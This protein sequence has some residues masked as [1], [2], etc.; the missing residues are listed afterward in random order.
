MADR[1][2][3]IRQSAKRKLSTNWTLSGNTIEGGIHISG[4]PSLCGNCGSEV[5]PYAEGYCPSCNH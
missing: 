5:P 2:Q 3:N 4:A 1:Q